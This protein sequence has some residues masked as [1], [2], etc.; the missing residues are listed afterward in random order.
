MGTAAYMSP[1]QA[2]GMEVDHRADIWSL[3]VILYEMLTGQLPFSG[4]YEQAVLYAIVNT[5]PEP[6]TK[7]RPET[8]AE[9]EEIVNKSLA[10]DLHVRYQQVN[11][12]LLD[13]RHFQQSTNIKPIA[14]SK[15]RPTTAKRRFVATALTAFAIVVLIVAGY[16][17]LYERAES[18]ERIP[19]AV[20]DFS[21]TTEE[22]ELDG[23]SGML[24]TSLE[25]SRR[26]SV[27]TRSRMFDILKQI[28][29]ENVER[30]DE[31]L[32][33]E[34]CK[35]ANVGVMAIASVRK[36]GRQYAIEL[37]VLDPLKDQYLF[38]VIKKGEGQESVLAMLDEI[39]EEVRIGLKEQVGQIEAATA[40]VAE[41]TSTNFEAYQHYFL[42]EQFLNKLDFQNAIKEFEAAIKLDSTFALAHY[43]LSYTT[44]QISEGISRGIIVS[45]SATEKAMKYI[46]TAP[47]KE[48]Y[49]IRAWKARI[50]NE[51]EKAFNLYQQA[52]RLYPDEKEIL[53][54]MGDIIFH[55]IS[56]F[57]AAIEYFDKVLASDPAFEL[58]LQHTISACHV[59]SEYSRAIDYAERFVARKPGEESYRLLGLS[60]FLNADFD[61][62]FDLYQR[63]LGLFPKSAMPIVGF[64]NYYLFQNDYQK[65]EAEFEKLLENSRPPS[66]KRIGYRH[67][68]SLYAHLGQYRK[69]DSIYDKVLRLDRESK[70]EDHL[71]RDYAEW[72]W[73]RIVG[74]ND[75]QQAEA[76]VQQSFKLQGSP[77]SWYTLTLFRVYLFAGDF[78]KS[79]LY[80][81][82]S[83]QQGENPH[84]YRN[85]LFD[86]YRYRAKRD[87]QSAIE[88]LLDWKSKRHLYDGFFALYPL[89]ECYLEIG[90][91]D[92]A[93]EAVRRMQNTYVDGVAIE[94]NFRGAIYPKGFYLLGKI[95]EKQDNKEL[96]IEN[97]EKLLSLW[98]DADKDLLELIDA[99][100]RL[101][102]LKGRTVQ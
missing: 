37:K 17:Q 82:K 73:W 60:Y 35:Q 34:I 66:M 88:K 28:G 36:F 27:L 33:R 52:L 3:G 51:N 95:Y 48:Q 24:I 31:T 41:V 53:F 2:Q 59:T 42:G 86:A 76:L 94:P 49:L 21:N 44:S 90:D 71:F 38:G 12:F 61:K 30:I 87:Y 10:K 102:K 89:A 8:P 85:I 96:A 55:S 93:I 46:H 22:K 32:G 98:K 63:A 91:T 13:L 29:K 75:L 70:N 84:P 25:Q 83:L 40:K 100:A 72:A 39:S 69:I 78:E 16:W 54:N 65:A 18:Q 57:P 11:D 80:L 58:A 62:A 9:L 14:K 1:Q 20:V 67:L 56:N 26:L 5:D 79:S 47:A 23:L 101:A 7:I 15:I 50:D 97:Y 92:K 19:I 74:K 43:R 81:S 45:K 77:D 99:K 6:I 64:G 4:H 68:A